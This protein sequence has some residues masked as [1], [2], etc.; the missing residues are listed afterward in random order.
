MNPSPLFAAER[1]GL[2]GNRAIPLIISMRA[3]LEKIL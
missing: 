2:D 3:L 1:Q